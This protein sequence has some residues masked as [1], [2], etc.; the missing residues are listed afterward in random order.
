MTKAESAPAVRH[1]RKDFLRAATGTPAWAVVVISNDN[2]FRLALAEAIR[3]TGT[4]TVVGSFAVLQETQEYRS[5]LRR[6]S[7]AVVDSSFRRS[8]AAKLFRHRLA[9]WPDLRCTWLS[10][11]TADRS[12]VHAGSLQPAETVQQEIISRIR[13]KLSRTFLRIV[14]AR[15]QGTCGSADDDFARTSP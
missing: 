11:E 13:T 4:A 3:D 1:R 10:S 15:M 2:L 7:I 14:L 6:A 8:A 5:A 9:E 12:D